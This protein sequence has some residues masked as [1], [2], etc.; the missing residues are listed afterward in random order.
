MVSKEHKPHS[1]CPNSLSCLTDTSARPQYTLPVIVRCAIMGS[2]KQRL[3]IREIY[4]AMEAKY[5]YFSNSGTSWKASP[6]CET[7]S[8]ASHMTLTHRNDSNPS[9][10]ICRSAASSRNSRGPLPSQGTAHTGRSIWMRHRG[11]SDH[12][13]GVGPR[14]QKRL[15]TKGRRSPCEYASTCRLE[16]IT[17]TERSRRRACCIP[18]CPRGHSRHA[19]YRRWCQTAGRRRRQ[20]HLT[21]KNAPVGAL[22]VP[23]ATVEGRG[24]GRLGC[25]PRHPNQ[26]PRHNTREK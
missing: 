20:S 14:R 13:S 19:N 24:L 21:A 8:S 18:P 16:T 9:A 6:F 15:S 10:I 3:T 26:E 2:L 17:R 11:Q 12:G 1:N 4:A 7:A 5:P 23:R 25:G 22:L